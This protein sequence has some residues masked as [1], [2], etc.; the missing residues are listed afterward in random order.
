M[1]NLRPEARQRLKKDPAYR[2][3]HGRWVR[4]AEPAAGAGPDRPDPGVAARCAHESGV[5][6]VRARL[7]PVLLARGRTERLRLPGRHA[8]DPA[9]PRSS[10][11]VVIS[12]SARCRTSCWLRRDR[13]Q[14]RSRARAGS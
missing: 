1:N 9:F 14:P 13:R 3:A 11:S 4:C 7:D 10:T 6:E 8:A 12:A 2:V 5:D